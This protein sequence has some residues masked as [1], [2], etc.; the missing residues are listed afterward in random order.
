MKYWLLIC[1]LFDAPDGTPMGVI[2]PMVDEASCREAI[3]PAA[4]VFKD[5]PEAVITCRAPGVQ[6]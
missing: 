3:V 2:I 5:F 6:S 1:W 4:E